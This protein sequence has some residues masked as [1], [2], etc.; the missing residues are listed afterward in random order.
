[1]VVGVLAVVAVPDV[2]GVAPIE[3]VTAAAVAV[4]VLA[5]AVTIA[6]APSS[7]KIINGF[8]HQCSIASDASDGVGVAVTPKSPLKF[9][10]EHETSRTLDMRR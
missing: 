7:R 2:V 6:G 10:H 9:S 8:P 3:G 4:G 5:T 1:M